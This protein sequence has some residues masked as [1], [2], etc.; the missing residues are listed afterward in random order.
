[1][2]SVLATGH[3]LGEER[4]WS[5]LLYAENWFWNNSLLRPF[6]KLAVWCS[7][8]WWVFD[9]FHSVIPLIYL[10]SVEYQLK[11]KEKLGKRTWKFPLCFVDWKGSLN[12][13]TELLGWVVD[14]NGCMSFP[15]GEKAL[16]QSLLARAGWQ[17]CDK[18]LLPSRMSIHGGLV[19]MYGAG[20]LE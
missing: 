11:K 14:L 5:R 16:V 20:S 4:L 1:M 2:W 3:E 8:Q 15:R 17:P 7:K 10:Q 19:G 9:F 13:W 12:L 6:G 18:M